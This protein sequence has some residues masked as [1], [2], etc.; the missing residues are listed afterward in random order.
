MGLFSKGIGDY[1][2]ISLVNISQSNFSINGLL[3]W[4]LS[5]GKTA[6]LFP[7]ET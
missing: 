6:L 7:K 2:H 1:T 4:P 3:Q 5:G